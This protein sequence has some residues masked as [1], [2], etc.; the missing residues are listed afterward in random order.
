[1]VFGS[2]VADAIIGCSVWAEVVWFIVVE[3]GVTALALGAS[4]PA[5]PVR[6]IAGSRMGPSTV[7]CGEYRAPGRA[8][9]GGVRVGGPTA[10]LATMIAPRDG[11][12]L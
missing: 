1:M 3:F 2:A 7:V 8:L 6:K 10:R 9:F 5:P 12:R 11:P 4:L